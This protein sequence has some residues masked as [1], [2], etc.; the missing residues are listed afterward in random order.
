MKH[1][2]SC[3]ACYCPHAC[4]CMQLLHSLLPCGPINH[5]QPQRRSLLRPAIHLHNL[6][7]K[8]APTSSMQNMNSC[9]TLQSFHELACRTSA[10]GILL[11]NYYIQAEASHQIT[12]DEAR[13]WRGSKQGCIEAAVAVRYCTSSMTETSPLRS[14][15]QPGGR[16]SSRGNTSSNRTWRSFGRGFSISCGRIS[17]RCSQDSSS[18]SKLCRPSSDC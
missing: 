11:Q 7:F 18:V 17:S 1:T 14:S 15:L 10:Q 16:D 12:G 2:Q 13:T 9:L 5:L 8:T 6:P 4:A 3:L